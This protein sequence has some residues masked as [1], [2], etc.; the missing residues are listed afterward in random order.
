M[1]SCTVWCMHALEDAL[2]GSFDLM[3]AIDHM[4]T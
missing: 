2:S 1:S 4:T 3:Q